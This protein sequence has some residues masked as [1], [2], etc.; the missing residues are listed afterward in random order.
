[1]SPAGPPPIIARVFTRSF[2]FTPR[3]RELVVDQAIGYKQ[4]HIRF[5]EDGDCSKVGRRKETTIAAIDSRALFL[6]RQSLGLAGFSL[7]PQAIR[8]N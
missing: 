1:M 8:D 3:N 5:R 6:Q 4:A 2:P 7:R